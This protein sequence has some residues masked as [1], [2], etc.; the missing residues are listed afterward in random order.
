VLMVESSAGLARMMDALC[1]LYGYRTDADLAQ[2]ITEAGYPVSQQS[3]SNYKNGRNPPLRYIVG[4][5]KALELEGEQRRELLRAY[6][7]MNPE[8]EDFLRL[9]ASV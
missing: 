7:D 4:Y 3:V 5:I 9:W 1:A 8:F 6:M 2:A